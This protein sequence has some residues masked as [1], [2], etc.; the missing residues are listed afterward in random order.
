MWEYVLSFHRV[1][2]KDGTH[3]AAP[4]HTKLSQAQQV[5]LCY[6]PFAWILE[7]EDDRTGM[8]ISCEVPLQL[9]HT[10]SPSLNFSRQ[11]LPQ[12]FTG[13]F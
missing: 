12:P 8:H 7:M 1:G 3:I 2:P 11:E 4:L 9:N 10:P 6:L 13:G 5:H